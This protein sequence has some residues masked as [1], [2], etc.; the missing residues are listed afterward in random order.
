MLARNNFVNF[1]FG[2]EVVGGREGAVVQER[3][4]IFAVLVF[5]AEQVAHGLDGNKN[6]GIGAVVAVLTDFAH[7][8]DHVEADTIQQDG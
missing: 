1:L 7:H 4:G 8:A 2:C 6:A 3:N 5:Q